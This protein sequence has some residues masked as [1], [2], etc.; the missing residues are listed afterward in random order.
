MKML[1]IAFESIIEAQKLL[2]LVTRKL[3]DKINYPSDLR[4][5]KKKPAIM[6][7]NYFLKKKQNLL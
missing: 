3:L 5:L 4:L 7:I 1:K 2:F 6:N